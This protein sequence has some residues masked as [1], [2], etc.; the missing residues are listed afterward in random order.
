MLL[1]CPN[2]AKQAPMAGVSP[3]AEKQREG[4]SEVDMPGGCPPLRGYSVHGAYVCLRHP[5]SLRRSKSPK[6]QQTTEFWMIPQLKLNPLVQSWS[7][8]CTSGRV[9]G[10]WEWQ[11]AKGMR[12]PPSG[13]FHT[14]IDAEAIWHVRATEHRKGKLEWGGGR[15]A[16]EGRRQLC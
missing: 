7:I 1:S 2:R 8:S 13:S 6:M 12:P 4:A 5:S 15:R 10:A 9:R 3:Q 14:H 11:G 16:A